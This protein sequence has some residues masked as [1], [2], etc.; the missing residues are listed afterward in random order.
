MTTA[1]IL[2]LLLTALLPFPGRVSDPDPGPDPVIGEPAPAFTLTDTH[3]KLRSLEDYRGRWVVLEWLNYGCPYVRKHYR[4]GNIPAQQAKWTEDGVVWLA[5]ASASPG[6]PGYLG[7]EELNARS[8][9]LGSQATAVLLDP[10]GRVG[11]AY[12]ARTTPHMFV[13]DP[14][15]ILVYM[16][17]IDDVPTAR[18]E[19]LARATQLVDRALTEAA[20]GRPVSVSTSRPYG[21][22]VKYAE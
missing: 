2:T 16:G 5:I 18:E 10:D 19:D 20:S 6:K 4:S 3:G 17:G 11:R 15:G 22:S 13:I 7:P 1:P 9:A 14:D 21:C 8:A 12:H